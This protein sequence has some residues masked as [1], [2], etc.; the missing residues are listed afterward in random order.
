[1]ALGSTTGGIFRLVVQE[2][3][4]IAGCGLALGLASAFFVGKIMKS[5]LYGVAQMDPLVI[6]AVAL[7]LAV[8]A[9]AASVIPSWRASA[10]NPGIVL[11]GS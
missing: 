1:M 5:H 6:S 9:L 3:M 4:G 2:G 7:I 8:I 10:I 11:N